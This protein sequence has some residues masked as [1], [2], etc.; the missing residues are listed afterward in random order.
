MDGAKRSN[1]MCEPLLAGGNEDRAEAGEDGLAWN[2]TRQLADEE[3][4]LSQ[5]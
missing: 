3:G 5:D 2:K 1:G 4:S